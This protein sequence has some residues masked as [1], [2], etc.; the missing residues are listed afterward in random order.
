MGTIV[1]MRLRDVSAPP[2][3]HQNM[4]AEDKIPVIYAKILHLEIV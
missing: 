2:L 1:V 4:F 3:N